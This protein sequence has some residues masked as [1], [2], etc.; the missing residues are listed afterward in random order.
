MSSTMAS[1]APSSST[2]PTTIEIRPQQGP[3]ETFLSTSA[4]IAIYGGAAGGGK[5]W[6]LLAEPLRHVNNPEFRAVI[7]RR[8][9]P[10]ITNPG[11]L[12]DE[13]VALYPRLG[14]EPKL[15][16][17]SWEFPSGAVVKL[18]H[19]QDEKALLGWQGA[20]I[21]LIEFDELTT[22]TER[23]FWFVLS[24]NRS[25]SGVRPYMRASCNPDADSWVK[26]LIEWWLDETTGLPIPER[27]GVLRWFYR[28]SGDIHWYDSAD[29]AKHAHPDLAAE[30]EPKSLTFIGA[31]VSDNPIL[32]QRNPEYLANLLALP[33][34]EQ[35]RFLRGNWLV[36]AVGGEWPASYFGPSIYFDDWPSHLMCRVMCLDPSKGRNAKSGDYSAWVF[37]GRD[38]SGGLWCDADLARRP[39]TRMLEDGLELY[40]AWPG[41]AEAVGVEGV[42]WQDLLAAEMARISRARGVM[43]PIYTVANQVPKDVRIRRIGP[44]LAR[45]GIRFRDTPSSRLLV[46][47]LKLF[48][49]GDYDD[50]P[51]ALEMC[52][53]VMATVLRKPG[54]RGQQREVVRL[55]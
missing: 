53:R 11:G 35:Q 46:S 16:E 28:V 22:F 1:Q 7:F 3:Q 14:A 54:E 43:L 32:L 18:G 5:S 33:F 51:D 19:L 41:H 40:H 13:S 26:K 23:Q 39:T 17:S 38:T 12:W 30:A 55:G 21:A 15:T 10:E 9:S 47:Q 45:K 20:Q 49:N 24:R 50:G 48:P 44:H 2:S 27:S 31:Q 37:L 8:T 25:T 42:L 6:A 29:D 34:I 4:D 36:S 52:L